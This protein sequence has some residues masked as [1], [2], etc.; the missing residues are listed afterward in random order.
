MY[1]LKDV[2]HWFRSAQFEVSITVSPLP[3]ADRPLTRGVQLKAMPTNT[4]VIY[5]GNA[6][7]NSQNG[8]VLQAGDSVLIPVEKMEW[9][10]TVAPSN[11]RLCV[12][13]M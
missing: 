6:D 7:V 3:S 12:L 4:D 10:Y 9:I 8:F 2:V 11:Q 5:I 1:V 13:A